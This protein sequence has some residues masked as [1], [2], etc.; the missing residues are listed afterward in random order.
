MVSWK[1]LDDRQEEK[2]LGLEVSI[3]SPCGP[4]CFVRRI[5]L[6]SRLKVIGSPRLGNGCDTSATALKI[7]SADDDSDIVQERL[8]SGFLGN[9]LDYVSEEASGGVPGH[10][11]FVQIAAD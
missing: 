3:P 9:R 8:K 2:L 10:G 4:L 11:G 1:V 7:L 5:L 6:L